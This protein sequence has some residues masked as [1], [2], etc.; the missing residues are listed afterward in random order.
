MYFCLSEKATGISKFTERPT[1]TAENEN[2]T[3]GYENDL[4]EQRCLDKYAK[5][6]KQNLT[7]GCKVTEDMYVTHLKDIKL[8]EY[9]VAV[10]KYYSIFHVA[11]ECSKCELILKVAGDLMDSGIVPLPALYRKHFRSTR[12]SDKAIR[13]VI[14]LPVVI[15][16]AFGQL[17]VTEYVEDV[18]FTKLASCVSHFVPE[19]SLTSGMSRESLK[20]LCELASSEK[21]RRLIRVA[22]SHGQTGNQARKSMGISNLR[23]ERERVK[24]AVKE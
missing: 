4:H 17:F 10:K 9:V 5:Y 18:D 8:N 6:V 12:K 15:F 19:K 3:V 16:R 20:V 13:R 24:E 23:A 21:D 2:V 22:A 14:Q 7:D 1:V 11:Q